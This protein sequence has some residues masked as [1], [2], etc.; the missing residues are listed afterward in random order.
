MPAFSNPYAIPPNSEAQTRARL[1]DQYRRQLDEQT[2]DRNR[3]DRVIDVTARRVRLDEPAAE[4]PAQETTAGQETNPGG[5]TTTQRP[6]EAQPQR[7]EPEPAPAETEGAIVYE[8]ADMWGAIHL[9]PA[10]YPR[11]SQID[12]TA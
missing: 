8:N 5:Q 10:P 9:R 2:E 12:L 7:L 4:R 6:F 11:G 1:Y 3:A